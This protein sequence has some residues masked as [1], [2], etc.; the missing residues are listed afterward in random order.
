M[1]TLILVMRFAVMAARRRGDSAT[2]LSSD[3]CVLMIPDS[4]ERLDCRYRLQRTLDGCDFAIDF[5]RAPCLGK[6]PHHLSKIVETSDGMSKQPL[7]PAW[8]L[9]FGGGEILNTSLKIFAVGVDASEGNFVPEDEAEV[10]LVR[11]NFDLA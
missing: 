1:H 3:Y 7:Q 10:D 11:G 5:D 8:V 9:Q 4:I 2:P 6:Y